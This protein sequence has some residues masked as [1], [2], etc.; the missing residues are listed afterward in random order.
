M[1]DKIDDLVDELYY[2]IMVGPEAF[3]V[4]PLVKVVLDRL[5]VS[6][7]NCRAVPPAYLCTCVCVFFLQTNRQCCLLINF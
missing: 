6:C 7:I 4:M 3:E 1:L 5:A 2:E